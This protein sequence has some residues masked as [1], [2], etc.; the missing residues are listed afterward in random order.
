MLEREA[1]EGLDALADVA[2]L[3]QRRGRYVGLI[4]GA[5][6]VLEYAE[7]VLSYSTL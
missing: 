6:R 2:A 3:S 1:R 4:G 7:K 5:K